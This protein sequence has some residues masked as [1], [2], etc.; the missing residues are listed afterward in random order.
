M[1]NA[2]ANGAYAVVNKRSKVPTHEKLTLQWRRKTVNKLEC[3]IISR[4]VNSDVVVQLPSHVWLCSPMDCCVPGLPVLHHLPKFA[5]VHVHCIGDAIQP[6]HPL[7]PPFPSTLNLS[8]HHGLFQWGRLFTSDDQNT[9]ASASA[10]VLLT[11]IQ[12][13]LPLRLTGF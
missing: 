8:Q 11:S 5:Q 12:D 6:S 4:L 2:V 3:N 13:W 9:G 1:T 7:M 10:S